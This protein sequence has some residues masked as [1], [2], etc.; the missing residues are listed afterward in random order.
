MINMNI[1]LNQ[2]TPERKSAFKFVTARNQFYFIH[3]GSS[4][5]PT[6]KEKDIL[7]VRPYHCNQILVGDVIAFKSS[8]CDRFI[9]HRISSITPK[10]ILTKGDNC[11]SLDPWC[12]SSES[13]IGRVTTLWR[14]GKK[15]I[16]LGGQA[17]QL[18]ARIFKY[19]EEFKCKIV[20]QIYP[21]YY[22]LTKISILHPIFAHLFN[23]K[24]V[25]FRTSDKTN[26]IIFWG[27]KA[28]GK[29][30]LR[31]CRWHIKEPF[32]ILIDDTSLPKFEIF[33]KPKC[34]LTKMSLTT[35]NN[36]MLE[37]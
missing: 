6:I 4:M 25:A 23:Q 27:T 34:G 33:L 8:N 22:F 24:F 18:N 17:G 3:R 14:N 15:R 9:A 30:D 26:I 36:E 11:K 12:L 10:G 19:I 21:F 2:T 28:I 29:F 16:I 35:A 20:C 7:E 31:L 5:N 37:A 13:I 32:R 1:E